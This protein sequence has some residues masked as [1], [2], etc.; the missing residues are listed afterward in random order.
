MWGLLGLN[1]RLLMDDSIWYAPDEVTLLCQIFLPPG[2]ETEADCSQG[3]PLPST[4]STAPHAG[5]TPLKGRLNP[6]VK[7]R[8]SCQAPGPKQRVAA[9]AS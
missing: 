5:A 3:P 7:L 2:G 8:P 1:K 6:S 4:D 9:L